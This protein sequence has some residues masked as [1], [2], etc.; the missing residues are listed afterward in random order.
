MAADRVAH[1]VLVR[2]V[3]SSAHLLNRVSKERSDRN[4]T[5]PL[6]YWIQARPSEVK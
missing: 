5:A 2:L 4:A 3:A 1:I 6:F